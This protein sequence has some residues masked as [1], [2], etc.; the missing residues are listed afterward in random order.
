MASK[1]ESACYR[2]ENAR[3]TVVHGAEMSK[4]RGGKKSK[5]Q[6]ADLESTKSLNR[7]PASGKVCVGDRQRPPPSRGTGSARGPAEDEKNVQ[8]AQFAI[9]RKQFLGT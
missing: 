3:G 5:I 9:R 2:R 7:S 4:Y 6:R 8:V 1:L